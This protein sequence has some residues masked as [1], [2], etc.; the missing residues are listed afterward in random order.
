M[1]EGFL[2]GLHRSWFAWSGWLF[3]VAGTV[4]A[5]SVSGAYA[6]IGALVA[7]TG[8]CALTAL[9][10]QRH[11]QLGQAE[12]RHAAD[13]GRL[14]GELR[15]AQEQVEQAE[16]K[17]NEVP[18]G[19]LLRLEATVRRHGFEDLAA[20]LSR[21]ASYVERMVALDQAQARSIT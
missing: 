3:T 15:I 8:L 18:L 16:R 19:L 14:E 7:G 12:E 10:Y 11:R 4:F 20:S 6:W 17:L 5:L 9:A 13:R 21:H 2:T 1:R